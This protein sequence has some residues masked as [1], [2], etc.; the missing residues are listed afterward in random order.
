MEF[1]KTIKKILRYPYSFIPYKYRYH[2]SY[3][4]TKNFL[5]QN[6]LNNKRD[7]R[8][9]QL[10]KIKDV[11]KYAYKN[12]PGY[13]HLYRDSNVQPT[14]L[15]KLSDFRF[16]PLI[17]K[18]ILRDNLKEFV[19]RDVNLKKKIYVT[20]SGSSGIPFG[21]YNTKEENAIELGFIH[22]AW[23]SI[24]WKLGDQSIVLRGSFI[25]TEKNLYYYNPS[26]KE[27][28]ISTYFLKQRTYN[29]FK[30]LFYLNKI[31]D[32]QAFPS[33]IINLANLVIDN[34]DIG[35]FDIRFVFLGS[36]NFNLWQKNIILRAF[37]KVKIFIWYGLTE[38]C[39]LALKHPKNEYYKVCNEYGYSEILSSRTAKREKI[40][41]N[42]E[43]IATSYFVKATPFIRYKTLDYASGEKD[44]NN[45]ISK[46]YKIEGRKH[47]YILTYSK[48]KVY[49]SSWSSIMHDDIFDMVKEFQF[50][51]KTPGIVILKIVPKQ[52][53][54]KL[55]E[56]NI[57]N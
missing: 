7:L 50:F 47:E 10:K 24:G 46:I 38:K 9:Y 27:L 14:D 16:F 1:N 32:I 44:I 28:H 13:Y 33:A 36:E 21:F 6:K 8:N 39:A 54:Q 41:R 53:F 12:C 34:K 22:N 51:Q 45:S 3:Y 5:K 31:K 30:K 43:I 20:T 57:Y 48:K 26:T 11:V 42:K 4:S 29:D 49:V 55:H 2:H 35:K 40:F 15:N 56:E 19:S 23:E 17:T 52:K 37:P 25:G 18:E